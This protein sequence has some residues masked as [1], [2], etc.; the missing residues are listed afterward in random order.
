M[1]KSTKQSNLG[2]ASKIILTIAISAILLYNFGQL[3]APPDGNSQS[4]KQFNQQTTFLD[5]PQ[6]AQGNPIRDITNNSEIRAF[7][8]E[9]IPEQL[10][11]GNIPGATVSVV[12]GNM[13]I[14]TQGY[15]YRDVSQFLPVEANHTLFR[16]GSI[17]KLFVWTAIMQLLEAE[18]IDLHTDINEYLSAFQ[19]AETFEDPITLWHL[20]T[21]TAGFEETLAP[22]ISD[23]DEFGSIEDILRKDLPPRHWAPG[24]I[25][26]YSN[27]GTTLAA[28]IIEQVAGVPFSD[29]IQTHILDPLNMTESSFLEPLPSSLQSNMSKGY[30]N[31]EYGIS[32]GFFEYFAV[33]P[34]GGF[35]TTAKDMAK[36][37]IANLNNGS[38]QNQQ[39]LE[40]A[41]LQLMQT[42]QFRPH[43]D[44][45]SIRLGFY[46]VNLGNHI[47][48]GHGGDT[49]FFHSQMTL[50]PEYSL[51]LFVSYNAA[52]GTGKSLQLHAKFVQEFLP[53]IPNNPPIPLTGFAQRV[54][55]YSGHY[56]SS[57][58]PYETPDRL[59]YEYYADSTF[60]LTTTKG[61]YLEFFGIRLVE[62]EE[63]VFRD[64]ESYG[65]KLY[66]VMDEKGN[67]DHFFTNDVSVVAYEKLHFY[68]LWVFHQ[69]SFWAILIGTVGSILYWIAEAVWK[70]FKQKKNRRQIAQSASDIA[71]IRE[72]AGEENSVHAANQETGSMEQPEISL[73]Q[74]PMPKIQVGNIF[75]EKP[76]HK[77]L[78]NWPHLLVL[79]FLVLSGIWCLLVYIFHGLRFNPSLPYENTATYFLI[80]P[81]F[82]LIMVLGMGFNA[83]A[84]WFGKNF[85]RE[86]EFP[87]KIGEKIHYT[88]VSLLGILWVWIIAYWN[89]FG[90]PPSGIA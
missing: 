64:I 22:I 28:F 12:R 30:A 63:G 71:H 5:P 37:M 16:V 25:P 53:K 79:V 76:K 56:E 2:S 24:T 77:H 72:P 62:I 36:F 75:Q 49:I 44:F 10:E 66:F 65:L 20:M 73:Q 59:Y 41:T 48:F 88:L 83:I 87:I 70:F 31:N 6:V 58:V 33:N 52:N 54:S 86:S 78:F 34:A 39:I 23:T 81:Y 11:K 4:K 38:Y 47:T 45:S 89:F 85:R 35:S 50:I 14:Y 57:R 67:V 19:I 84:E 26:S 13:T 21:H 40:P 46:D 7:F 27:F 61:G 60:E 43:P 68:D 90:F 69:I 9:Y 3:N 18:L 74:P 80:L 29:Y 15:G 17:S 51:G 32:E 8:D 82:I 55:K 42:P 1:I